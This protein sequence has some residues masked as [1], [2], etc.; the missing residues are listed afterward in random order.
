[1]LS[2]SR[3]SSKIF[4]P[5]FASSSSFTHFPLTILK[6]NDLPFPIADTSS[7]LRAL[8]IL[9]LF[10][11]FS[12]LLRF[13]LY[14]S[15]MIAFTPVIRASSEGLKNL[16]SRYIKSFRLFVTRLSTNKYQSRVFLCNRS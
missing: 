1:M 15:A 14:S 13:L 9:L 12:F 7:P 6:A 10:E 3:Y 16:L 4:F 2:Y 11:L 8:S 5:S